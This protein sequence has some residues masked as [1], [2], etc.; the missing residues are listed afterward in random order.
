MSNE[1]ALPVNVQELLA[2]TGQ[3]QGGSSGPK[4][5]KFRINSDP[6]DEQGNE[7]PVGTYAVTTDEKTFFSKTAKFTPYIAK[8]RY[9]SYDP[10]AKKYNKLSTLINS[11]REEAPDNA[12]GI[13]CG[14]V[15]KKKREGMS[16]AQILEA[17]NVKIVRYVYGFLDIDDAKNI[18]VRWELT[19][20]KAMQISERIDEVTKK[21]CP[22]MQYPWYMT[23]PKYDKTGGTAPYYPVFKPIDYTKPDELN[24]DTLK[25]LQVFDEIIQREN[26]Y[27]I[28]VHMKIKNGQFNSQDQ[29]KQDILSELAIDLNDP[30]PENMT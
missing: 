13:N 11:L 6:Q 9:R 2:L 10:T 7:L 5:F 30:L 28:G 16:E 22:L 19:G 17:Q 21:K 24:Q 3:Y 8:Y 23:A 14:Y 15:T 12:G 1:V 4:T 20:K 18:P 25:N 29:S 27:I 26:K